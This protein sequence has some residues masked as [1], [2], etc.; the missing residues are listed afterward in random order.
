MKE[1]VKELAL[2]CQ[3][4]IEDWEIRSQWALTQIDK[5]RAPL[6]MVASD[7]YDTMVDCIEE[8][9]EEAGLDPDEIDD[10]DIEDVLFYC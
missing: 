2:Y 6:Y 7:L 9:C 5:W 4:N 10:I 3:A 8:Y 1:I